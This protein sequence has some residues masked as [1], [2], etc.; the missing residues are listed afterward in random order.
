MRQ[1]NIL[2]TC[3][4]IFI[5]AFLGYAFWQSRETP[6]SIASKEQQEADLKMAEKYLEEAEPE[7]S[8]PI[9]HQYKEEME[10][11]TPAGKKW[12]KLFVDA[13][14]KLND[15]DQLLLI[16]QFKQD[17]L[18]N[19]E[20]GALIL[21][22]IFLKE[23]EQTEFN[24]VRKLWKN[25]ENNDAA[26]MLLDA[27]FLLQQGQKQHA[28]DLL[29]DK[30]WS[31]KLE[32]ERLMRLALIKLQENPVEALQILNAEFSRDPRNSEIRL[33]RGKIHESLNNISLAE[34][35][36]TAAAAL[37][38]KN[39]YLQ[40]QLAEFYRRQK[41]YTKALTI[42]QKLLSQSP[43]DHI[44]VK[45]LFWNQVAIPLAYNW[46]NT[47][48]S[49]ENSRSFLTYL[50]AL[51]SGQFWNPYAFEKI[52]HHLSALNDYQATFWLRLLQALKMHDEQSAAILLRNNHFE[53]ISW[54]PLL[55]ISL[56]R[57]LNYRK[58]GSLLIEGDTQNARSLLNGL[59]LYSSV[60][61]LYKTLDDL[62]QQ[63][64]NGGPNFKMPED[65]QALLC[66][67][68]IFTTALFSE[69]WTE[70]ALQL[71]PASLLSV[72]FPEWVPTLYVNGL[73]QNRGNQAAMKFALQ[74][75]QNPVI[76]LLIA[77]I[78]IAEG[79]ID[80]AMSKLQ[81]LKTDQSDIGSRAA[82][83]LSLMDMEKGNYRQAGETIEAHAKLAQ[84]LLGQEALGRIAVKEGNFEKAAQ[85]YQNIRNQSNEA[86]SF[87]ARLAFQQK[88]WK[89][90]HALTEDL[91]NQFPG[92]IQ[93]QENIKKIIAQEKLM[94][95]ISPAFN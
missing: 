76:T 8:L 1:S 82:W 74:Q 67:Q 65:V 51:K 25:R 69:G 7:R 60:P 80:Q 13:S 30:K 27:D 63:E 94:E 50:L 21:A 2:I 93:L 95:N 52:P 23:G 59:P 12:L 17:I 54:A 89:E 39:I 49:D 56:R 14:T 66:N 3:F 29:K 61:T 58:N 55:E 18:K 91:L 33:Y 70:A 15:T 4:I 20:Q 26:W 88:N 32:S 72:D 81:K 10:K 9:I 28:Y 46:K 71:Q 43:N 64:A 75:K 44:W 73:R 6:F 92:N 24:N 31:G 42:W 77:E 22:N 40:D 36:Y 84:T 37:E 83:L 86:K 5:L 47:S 53:T 38:P 78:E 57:I 41:N 68:E 19:N 11:N 16:Y 48:F 79:K 34:Q 85:I 87:L 62:A 90:A 45:G 35:D